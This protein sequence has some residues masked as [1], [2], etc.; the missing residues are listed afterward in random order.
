MGTNDAL[1]EHITLI[2]EKKNIQAPLVLWMFYTSDQNREHD[3]VKKIPF[4]CQS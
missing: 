3:F 1:N 4:S 2:E